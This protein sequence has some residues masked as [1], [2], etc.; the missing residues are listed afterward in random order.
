[1]VKG[2]TRSRLSTG[3]LSQLSTPQYAP[4][5]RTIMGRSN[6]SSDQV[7]SYA[8]QFG[9]DGTSPSLEMV[10]EWNHNYVVRSLG[11]FDKRI[12]IGDIASS[13]S[14][15]ELKQG[16]TV[17]IARDFAPLFP[18]SVEALSEVTF[19]GGNVSSSIFFHP[20]AD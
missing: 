4:L 15:V 8:L 11:S 3:T 14:L 13:V 6:W 9:E 19:I 12:V 1:M 2:L 10:G 16:K 20:G 7:V 18:F 5:L 17:P